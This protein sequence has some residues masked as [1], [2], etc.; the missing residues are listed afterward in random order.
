MEDEI[1]EL[2]ESITSRALHFRLMRSARHARVEYY[3]RFC[4][5]A[6][7]PRECTNEAHRVN[8]TALAQPNPAADMA[9]RFPQLFRSLRVPRMFILLPCTYVYTHIRKCI[10]VRRLIRNRE[11]IYP[12]YTSN[13]AYTMDR[14]G[15]SP[16][17]RGSY[18]SL[19]KKSNILDV[20]G[21]S[22]GR[23]RCLA[24]RIYL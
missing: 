24:A 19:G 7:S 20:N 18:E 10:S 2:N 6:R 3:K 11:R 1:P 4:R 16:L 15:T 5:A 23:T 21:A 13:R 14:S 9:R 22:E 17:L 12:Q 8:R